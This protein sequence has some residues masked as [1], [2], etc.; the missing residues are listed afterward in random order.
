M[1]ILCSL[2]SVIS[3]VQKICWIT[4]QLVWGYKIVLYVD[5][6]DCGDDTVTVEHYCGSLT[7]SWFI[8]TGLVCCTKELSFCVV[9][10]GATVLTRLVSIYGTETERFL[11]TLPSVHILCLVISMLP[12]QK[13]LALKCFAGDTDMQQA[14]SPGYRRWSDMYHLHSMYCVCILVRIK[15]LVCLLPFRTSL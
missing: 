6:L 9:M 8:T 3:V 15:S 12:L 7:R 5:F 13:H 10:P 14:L 2:K 1:Q 11:T 4:W